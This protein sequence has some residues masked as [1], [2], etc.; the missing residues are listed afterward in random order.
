MKHNNRIAP[1]LGYAQKAVISPSNIYTIDNPD[2]LFIASGNLFALFIPTEAEI[3]NVDLLVRRIMVSRL[4]YVENMKTLLLSEDEDF[5]NKNSL[6]L[7]QICHRILDNDANKYRLIF[8]RDRFES[9]TPNIGAKI[10]AK[11]ARLYARNLRIYQ[12]GQEER[13]AFASFQIDK[14]FTDGAIVESWSH[15]QISVKD[16]YMIDDVLVAFKRKSTMTFKKAFNNLMTLSFF[17]NYAI[18]DDGEVSYKKTLEYPKMIN[19]DFSF[20]RG[21]NNDPNKYIRVLAFMG[22]SPIQ[23]DSLDTCF[24]IKEKLKQEW[25]NRRNLQ[26]LF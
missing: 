2:V 5:L 22:L 26:R 19:S 9:N 8:E 25:R 17:L 15:S 23:A 20:F 10:R 11:Q 24:N 3:Q 7:N 13:R 21:N 16:A 14:R 6:L 4:A 18:H 1:I 12:L